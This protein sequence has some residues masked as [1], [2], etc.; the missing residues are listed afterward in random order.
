MTGAAGATHE[1][2]LMRRALALARHGWGQTAPNPM[3]GAVVVRDGEI[4]GEGFHET[5]GGPHAEVNALRA[6][7]E[8]AR[9]AT[10]V[11]SLEPCRHHGKTPPCTDAIIAAGV[12]RVVIG[13]PDPTRDASG[14][15]ALL[16]Q[17]GLDVVTGV[18]AGESRELN[19]AFFHAQS[20]RH[21]W[22]TLKLA[23]SI[24]TAIAGARG[25]TSHL[26]G[27]ESRREV[28]LLRS[29]HDAIAV[30]SG[31]VL[32]DDP[33]LTVRGVRPPR[34][35][36][37]RVIFDRALRLP[38]TANV[39]RTVRDAP[40]IVVTRDASTE[41]ARALT[42]AGVDVMAAADLTAGFRR[43]REA[44]IR[45]LLVEGGAALA[46]AVLADRLA[47]RLVI[48]QAPVA[49]GPRALHAFDGA[50][51]AVLSELERHPVLER[52]SLGRDVM[53][54]YAPAGESTDV[55]GSG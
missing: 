13:A 17:A 1:E 32:T 33:Q 43:L 4:V 6:A 26:T 29:G 11:V 50:P 52:R 18:L 16:R 38:L 51:P 8:R 28:H 44:G 53:T 34:V 46:G 42:D 19:A 47:H 15:A 30:G 3:V 9:G 21:P 49:L 22:T 25:S 12:R 54:T 37:T 2:A 20:G 55:H 5:F 14:G 27:P 41:R 36:L 24:E 23:V 31:T 7:G 39:V 48:F 45:S 35:P 10:L 40:T